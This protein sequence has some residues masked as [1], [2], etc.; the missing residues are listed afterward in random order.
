MSADKYPLPSYAVSVWVAGDNLMVAFPGIASEQGHTIKLPASAAG[1][2]TIVRILRDRATAQDLRL[3]NAGTPS[4]YD[5]EADQRYAIILK[6][7]KSEDDAARSAKA[8][9]ARELQELGL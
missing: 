5:L 8:Q 1:F 2:Q 6:A 9:A 7:M 3:G 4:Q